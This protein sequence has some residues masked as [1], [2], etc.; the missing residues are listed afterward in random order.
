M[1]RSTEEKKLKEIYSDKTNQEIGIILSKS[2]NSINNKAHRLGLKKSDEFILWRNKKG[3]LSKVKMG[4]RDLNYNTLKI[5]CNKYTSKM[6]FIEFDEPAF[7]ACVRK[8]Y[9]K[10]LTKHMTPFKYS[11]PQLIL[12]DLMNQ[13]LN[14]KASYNNRSVIKPYELDLYYHEFKLAF[15]YQGKY[16]HTLENNDKLKIDLTNQLGVTL[17]PIYE[18]SRNYEKDIKKQIK[19]NLG[20]INKIT[21]LKLNEGLVNDVKICNVF[22]RIYN[23]DKLIKLCASYDSFEDFKNTN[24]KE[25]RMLLKLKIVDEATKHMNDKRVRV[26][27]SNSQINVIVS[28]YNNLTDFRSEQLKLYKHIKRTNKNHLISHLKRK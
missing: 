14:S 21:N 24:K 22:E 6:E 16:W 19:A 13:L 9:L 17:I 26:K 10:E 8:G 25:Y 18:K 5:I 12:E 11:I 7:Q 3:H 23:K 4:Y 15:E 28:G 20:L 27:L 1:W 2:K